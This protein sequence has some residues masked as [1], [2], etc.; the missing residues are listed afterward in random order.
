[1]YFQHR[2]VQS[3]RALGAEG[4]AAWMSP[5]SYLSVEVSA[6]YQDLRNTST[7]GE[8]AEMA[9]DR[10]PNLPWLFGSARARAQLSSVATPGDQLALGWTTRYTHEF[11][12]FWE[13]IARREDKPV[14][15]AQFLHAA[16]LT[17]VIHGATTVSSTLEVQNITDAKAH[18][19]YG[20][21]KPGR[22]VYFKGMIEL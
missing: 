3:V 18:D 16:D 10:I 5:G 13:S 9:G 22:A 11:F 14:I 15:E 17:Y 1:M 12:R 4:Q 21:Q 6:T 20:V 8:F 2:N 19:F 7:E